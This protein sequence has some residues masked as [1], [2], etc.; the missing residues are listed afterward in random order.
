MKRFILAA[1]LALPLAAAAGQTATAGD[2]CS[3]TFR[4]GFSMAFKGWAGC[5]SEP[6][7]SPNPNPSC[8]PCGGGGCNNCSSACVNWGQLAPWYQ[9]WPYDGHFQTSAPTGFPGYPPAMTAYGYGGYGYGAAPAT[10]YGY[11]APGGYPAMQSGYGGQQ[12]APPVQP[13][14]YYY[15]QTQGYYYG[16]R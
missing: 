14:A 4:I 12:V 3:P 15:P 9:Y 16:G 2:C 8:N 10:A 1:L 13:A 11:P 6:G 5:S 7:C